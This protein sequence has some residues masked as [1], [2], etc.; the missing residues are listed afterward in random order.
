MVVLE[1]GLPTGFTLEKEYLLHILRVDG[2]KLVE[3]KKSDS[4]AVIYLDKMIA[5]EEK[6]LNVD[7]FRTHKV[8]EQK[9]VAVKI[10]DYY[11]SC[12]YYLE[13]VEKFVFLILSFITIS[14]RTAREFYSMP[15]IHSCDICEGEECSKACK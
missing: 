12:T 9:P 11:D 6:C 13:L 4:I 2:V 1:V 7:G 8:A 3:T 5:N 10:Y 15:A 14:A